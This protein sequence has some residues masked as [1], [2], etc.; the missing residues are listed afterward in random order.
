M[1]KTSINKG[2]TPKI[3]WEKTFA[4][5]HV[6]GLNFLQKQTNRNPFK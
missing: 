3:N 6:Q 4:M 2:G 1:A 5:H